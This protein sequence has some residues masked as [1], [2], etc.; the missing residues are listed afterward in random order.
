[1]LFNVYISVKFL[2]NYSY[3]DIILALES[4]KLFSNW[5]ILDFLS[6][7]YFSSSVIFS[8]LFLFSFLNFNF[9]FFRSFSKSLFLLF[10]SSD[11][12]LRL[13]ISSSLSVLLPFKA[14]I[15]F[16]KS[17]HLLL[18]DSKFVFKSLFLRFNFLF[19]KI[20]AETF[21]SVSFI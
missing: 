19:Y 21:S 1:M 17:S 9:H 13:L 4:D 8:L 18:E 5:E 12:R 15:Y 10:N 6:S 16:Y 20:L 14:S 2:S 11:F 3:Y 7:I